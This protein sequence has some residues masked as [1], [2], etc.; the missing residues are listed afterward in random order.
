MRDCDVFLLAA[1]V[2]WLS[3]A[4]RLTGSGMRQRR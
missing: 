2:A 3:R 1:G 4:R